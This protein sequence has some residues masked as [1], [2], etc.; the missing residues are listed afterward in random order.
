[1]K[2]LSSCA[3]FGA[4]RALAG[5]RDGLILQHSVVGC[6]WG[7]LAFRYAG[8][9][10]NV[11]QASDVIYNDDVI[12]GGEQVLRKAL[13][14]A[15]QVFSQC[16]AVF[17]VSGCVPNMIG[18]DVEGILADSK[19]RQKLVH[20]K[21]PGYAG[22]IDS[23]VE[24]AYLALL[25]LMKAAAKK[26]TPSINLL[27]IMNDD[28]YEDNDLAELRKILGTKVT[29]NCAVQDC[30]LQDIEAMPQA[31]LNICFGYGEVLAQKM[32]ERFGVSYLKC[33]YPYGAFG[34]Q[35]FLRQL[36][37]SLQVDFSAEIAELE[38]AAKAL[39]YRC[40]DYLMNL[41][42]LPVAV[43]AD[44]AHLQGLQNFLAEEL[45]LR[46]VIAEDTANFSLDAMEK[47]ARRSAPV[48]LCGSSFLKPLAAALE[49][50]LV[51]AAYP[52]FDKLC[53]SDTTLLGTRGAAMLIE[54]IVNGALQQN[55]K[56][57]GL[58]APLRDVL[59]EVAYERN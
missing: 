41:Y 3:L 5:I 12:N 44:K 28:P 49:V 11:R 10:Y 58:Y 40:A 16:G 52:A 48:L 42:Q 55:Y 17:V 39:A 21:A 24:A 56:A 47:A 59:C 1:M 33:A 31:R 54:E 27:G 25:P 6:Q 18:D 9:P 37:E 7:S 32:Q 57:A 45:G 14:E 29:I 4:T 38:S 20:V 2:P 35:N 26:K 23:G 15:E 30:S 22:N 53:F 51:R 43:A 34:L 19:S 50:P 46:V 36:E 8:K 13:Q